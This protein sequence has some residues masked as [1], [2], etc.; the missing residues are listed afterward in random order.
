[1]LHGA[2]TK[3]TTDCAPSRFCTVTLCAHS[4]H[5]EV[6]VMAMSVTDSPR[7]SRMKM[8]Y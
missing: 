7:T 1:M 3:S 6:Q 4:F 8:S 2:R 5:A